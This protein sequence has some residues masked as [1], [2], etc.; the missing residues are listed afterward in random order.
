MRK[1][2][3]ALLSTDMGWDHFIKE[4]KQKQTRWISRISYC[5]I[6]AV[7]STAVERGSTM[8]V[9]EDMEDKEDRAENSTLR[10]PT[11]DYLNSIWSKQSFTFCF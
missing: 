1:I 10:N 11:S 9:K 2:K 6:C 8:V 3:P 7:I 5:G 4:E